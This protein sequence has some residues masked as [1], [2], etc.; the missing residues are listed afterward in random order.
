MSNYKPNPKKRGCLLP[1]GCKNLLD[2]KK[3]KLFHVK[4]RVNGRICS[5]QVELRNE[6]GKKIGVFSIAEALDRARRE[7][8]DLVEVNRKV[9]PSICLLIDYGRF[10]FRSDKGLIPKQWTV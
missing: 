1:F 6:D 7:M 5:D 8:L 10:K 2:V 4:V 9:T 3:K